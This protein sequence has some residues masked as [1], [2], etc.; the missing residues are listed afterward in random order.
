MRVALILGLLTTAAAAD[1]LD[2]RQS[3]LREPEPELSIADVRFTW[4]TDLIAAMRND[5]AALAQDLSAS[6]ELA[7]TGSDCDFVAAGGQADLQRTAEAPLALQQWASVCPLSGV[8]RIA[9]DHRLVWDVR[10][11]LLAPP[12]LRPD[13]NRSETV[14][15][16]MS[17]WRE[18]PVNPYNRMPS[19]R[20]Y[21]RMGATRAE[22]T[23]PWSEDG[24]ALDLAMTVR[25]DAIHY[26]RERLD[27]SPPFELH[28][29]TIA[30]DVMGAAEPAMDVAGRT[31]S[32]ASALRFDAGRV[33][34]VRLGGGV[35]LGAALGFGDAMIMYG[36]RT[37]GMVDALVGRAGLSLERDLAGVRARVEAGR[38]L[39]PTW[40]GRAVIDDRVTASAAGAIG[41]VR[42]RI[43]L[44][45]AAARLL[46]AGGTLTT[47]TVGGLSASG[48]RALTGCLTARGYL[49]VG[50]SVYAAGASFEAPRWAAEGMLSLQLHAGNR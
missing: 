2:L 36:G 17:L 38:D 40:D 39:W 11:R 48:E 14:G 13:G 16:E 41:G 49:E 42:G 24:A 50:R 32:T 23:A 3:T 5:G 30:A 43:A 8:A 18:K 35:R 19:P 6:A 10:P 22:I 46:T 45:A 28:V 33:E 47:T 7:V 44:S 1:P 9:I 31:P 37:P 15:V 20:E 21:A 29:M 4:R 27:G 25:M 26:T 12:R 34:G